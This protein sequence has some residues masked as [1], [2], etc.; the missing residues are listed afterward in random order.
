[1]RKCVTNPW[2]ADCAYNSYSSKN[3]LKAMSNALLRQGP[4][5]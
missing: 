4:F 1:M 5:I 2:P 3:E